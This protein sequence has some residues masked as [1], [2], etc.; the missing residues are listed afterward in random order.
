MFQSGPLRLLAASTLVNNFGNGAFGAAAVVFLSEIVG[1]S[2]STIGVGLTISAVVGLLSSL[3]AGLISDRTNAAMAAGTLLILASVASAL[4]AVI[5]SVV[6]FIVVAA[7]FALPERSAAV[8]RQSLVGLVFTGPTRT[9]AR[10]GLRSITNIGAALGGGLAALTL[11]IGSREAFQLLFLVN[12][13][14]FVIAGVLI[15]RVRSYTAVSTT[16]GDSDSEISTHRAL[17]D[18][19]YVAVSMV[20]ALLTIHVVVLDVIMPIWV[21]TRTQAPHSVVAALLISNTLLVIAFQLPVSRPFETVHT[22]VSGLRLSGLLLAAMFALLALSSSVSVWPA[23]ILL[24]ISVIAHTGAEM[25]QGASSWPLSYDLAPATAPWRVSRRLE[26]VRAGCADYRSGWVDV[27]LVQL[28]RSE[29]HR[30]SGGLVRRRYRHSV[31]CPAAHCL[32]C[33]VGDALTL[34]RP[35]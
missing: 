8:A 10:A 22:A 15:M 1:L 26:F 30:P 7:V 27:H 11:A 14:S 32:T 28:V 31:L 5:D 25:V 35:L 17:R 13:A 34:G 21:V 24:F 2:A 29:C 6:L 16:L 23:V 4:Y 33:L 9:A 12:A 20:N 18:R 3:P 19:P